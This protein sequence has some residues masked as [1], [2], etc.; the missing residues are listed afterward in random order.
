MVLIKKI[1]LNLNPRS[2]SLKS[3]AL[4]LN[5]GSKINF[6]V[7]YDFSTNEAWGTSV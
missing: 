2:D 5:S 4:F 1:V 7:D 3:L 6:K